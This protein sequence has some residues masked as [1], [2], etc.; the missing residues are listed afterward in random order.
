MYNT[1]TCSR[2]NGSGRYSFCERF[3]DI[4]FKC[5]ESGIVMPKEYTYDMWERC[6]SIDSIP[7]LSKDAAIEIARANSI[8]GRCTVSC[9]NGW[10]AQGYEII[11]VLV[12]QNGV[13]TNDYLCGSDD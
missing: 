8:A 7:G 11:R 12:F 13:Q 10:D 9:S 2:C 6:K 3:A 4:C 1:E 5:G